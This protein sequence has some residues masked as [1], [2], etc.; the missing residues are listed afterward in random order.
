VSALEEK[1]TRSWLVNAGIYVLAPSV[2]ARVAPRRE[3]TTP[4]LVAEAMQA[5]EEVR[6]LEIEDDWI[7]VGHIEQ[8]T[9]AR[10]DVA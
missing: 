9:R 5:G 7:D 10:G 2:V 3:T 6:A 1:P 4:Q 8:F